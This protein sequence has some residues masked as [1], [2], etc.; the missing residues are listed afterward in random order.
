MME[1]RIEYYGIL[2]QVCGARAEKLELRGD[3]PVS[4]RDAI[5]SLVERHGGL[6]AHRQ[7]MAY[8]VGETLIREDTHVHDGCVLVL[9]P[10]VSG[11]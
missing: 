10:P 11:G 9:L 1:I 2:E 6:E 3:G 8:A 5:D 4:V 7:H